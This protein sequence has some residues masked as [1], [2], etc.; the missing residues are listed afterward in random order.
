MTYKVRYLHGAAGI[1]EQVIQL[2]VLMHHLLLMQ[3]RHAQTRLP[4]PCISANAPR[5][6]ATY[7]AICRRRHSGCFAFSSSELTVAPESSSVMIMRR[8]SFARQQASAYAISTSG[9]EPQ[10]RLRTQE[11]EDVWMAQLCEN[12]YLLLG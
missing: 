11:R 5:G 9:A 12:F 3:P 10:A 7:L 2:Q 1:E 4:L 8:P 6:H